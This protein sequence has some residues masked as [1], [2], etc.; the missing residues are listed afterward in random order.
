M[1]FCKLFGHRPMEYRELS[2]TGIDG[3]GRY[4]AFI[5]AFCDR[6]GIWYREG[7]AHL[8][9]MERTQQPK[10]PACVAK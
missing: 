4:H 9:V 10:E 1:L 6:C 3:I 7:K 5:Y 8:P 2:P